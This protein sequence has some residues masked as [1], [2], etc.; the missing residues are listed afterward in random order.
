L[1][2][3]GEHVHCRLRESDLIRA[4]RVTLRHLER[5]PTE[6]HHESVERFLDYS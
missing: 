1:F 6:D 2:F 4:A 5:V 3:G